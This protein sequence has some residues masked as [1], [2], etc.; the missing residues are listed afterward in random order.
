MLCMLLVFSVLLGNRAEMKREAEFHRALNMKKEEEIRK[1]QRKWTVCSCSLILYPEQFDSLLQ[2]KESEAF[3]MEL[4]SPPLSI[5]TTGPQTHSV[6]ASPTTGSPPSSSSTTGP[7]AHSATA[8][9]TT[10][11]PTQPLVLKPTQRLQLLP[12]LRPL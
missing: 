7:Q 4:G 5:S 6:T 1:G 11:H 12:Q 8:S 9:L 2:A 3:V 10:L